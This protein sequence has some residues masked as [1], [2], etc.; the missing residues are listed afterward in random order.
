MVGGTTL[1]YW[2]LGNWRRETR[3][4]RTNTNA[5]TLES[6]GRSMK[7]REIMAVCP[8]GSFRRRVRRDR[9]RGG[10]LRI[11]LGAGKGPL[12]PLGHHPV[13][14]VESGFDDPKLAFSI[15]GLHDFA[16]DDIV[17]ADHQHIAA[18]LVRPDRI[19]PRQ[20]RLVETRYRE[21]NPH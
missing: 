14:R 21:P 8:E 19:V 16:L 15:S 1:G 6:T 18:F 13:A 7:K 3:P 5:I 20:Q 10:P 9:R 17:R 4:I 12:N 2:A 11:D